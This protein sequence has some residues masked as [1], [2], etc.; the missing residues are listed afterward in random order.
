VVFGIQN[1]IK[2]PPFTK[3]DLICCRNLLIYFDTALQKKILPIFHY[4]LKPKGML[5]LGTS[6]AVAGYVDMFKLVVTK[7][8]IFE[9]KETDAQ[10]YAG[11][12][13][14]SLPYY[15][16][17]SNPSVNATNSTSEKKSINA[18]IEQFLIDHYV[19]ACLIVNKKG[20]ILYVHGKARHYLGLDPKKSDDNLLSIIKGKANKELAAAMNKASVEKQNITYRDFPIK[21]GSDS[22]SSLD[23]KISQIHDYVQLSNMLLILFDDPMPTK[24]VKSI[25][26]YGSA[27]QMRHT[28]RHLEDELQYSKE[29]LQATIEELQSSNEE[30]Q[31]ANE[32][33]QSTNEEIET[34]KEELQ[35]LNEELVSVN[36]E[37]QVKLDQ[38]ASIHDD[39]NNLFNSTEIAA[40]FLD[41]DFH[42]KRFTPKVQD[43]IHIIHADIGR[44]LRD[45]ATNIKYENLIHEAKEVQ[46]TLIPKQFEVRSKNN[47]SYLVRILPYRTLANVIDGVII[48]FED[49]TSHKKSEKELNKVNNALNDALTFAHSIIDSVA[50]PMLVLTEDLKIVSANR[51]FYNFFKVDPESTINQ[52]LYQLGNGQWD[53]PELRKRLDEVIKKDITVKRFEFTHKFPSIGNKHIVL[54]ALRIYR[55]EIQ[56]NSILLVIREK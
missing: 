28:I 40:I 44:S 29:N 6:E 15:H 5:F 35:S 26:V 11:F 13:F 1:I 33:L 12:N 16:E 38:L 54:D 8:K 3:L 32:E 21:K 45:F 37:L 18:A 47:K 14:S 10:Q 4:S 55:H 49:I 53:I 31:S 7:W 48:V 20:D 2:D 36:S 46:K 22:R 25:K 19:P 24:S 17:Y 34:S 50:E 43:L 39:M 30:L 27:V 52:L 51:P 41:N 56:T 23:L 42:I 9:K